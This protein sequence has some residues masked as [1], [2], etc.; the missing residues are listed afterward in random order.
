MDLRQ[1]EEVASWMIVP[2]VG[3]TPGRLYGHSIV[4]TKPH[5][6][7]FGGNTGDK[8]INDVWCLNVERAPFSWQRIECG[9]EGPS[10]RV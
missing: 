4:F 6:L 1:G 2:V 8:P 10:P 5:L 3:Q 9:G 7:V